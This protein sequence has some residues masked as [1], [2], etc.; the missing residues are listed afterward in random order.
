MEERDA[1]GHLA[2]YLPTSWLRRWP[3]RSRDPSPSACV[4]PFV[5]K[6]LIKLVKESCLPDPGPAG[7]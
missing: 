5:V 1:R 2:S 7:S 4:L 3:S 6:V